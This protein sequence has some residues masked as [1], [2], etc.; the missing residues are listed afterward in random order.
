MF[1]VKFNVILS[2]SQ[3]L[4]ILA[5]LNSPLQEIG[6]RYLAWW[7]RISHT[8]SLCGKPSRP[9]KPLGKEQ[10]HCS[11]CS[12]ALREIAIVQ[13]DSSISAWDQEDPVPRT[14]CSALGLVAI[15]MWQ[16]I[17]VQR[18][19]E[20]WGLPCTPSCFAAVLKYTLQKINYTTAAQHN[21]SSC[22]CLPLE[23]PLKPPLKL[24]CG[25]GSTL[26]IWQYNSRRDR[27]AGQP[28]AY[29]L[30]PWFLHNFQL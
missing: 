16:P 29:L 14:W 20:T 19:R 15:A 5:C 27:L 1:T 17:P 24:D 13:E 8:W 26:N 25:L 30:L 18:S 28:L 10:S 9:P 22:R 3:S 11:F 7:M 4:P 2:K 21:P 23:H 6:I 12:T